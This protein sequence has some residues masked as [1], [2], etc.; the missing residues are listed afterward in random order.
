MTTHKTI[1]TK[2]ALEQEEHSIVLTHEE[3]V[4]FDAAILGE[5]SW[6]PNEKLLSAVEYH[7]KAA[8]EGRIKVR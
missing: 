2:T 1:A 3:T 8:A 4:R 6:T 7:N 5:D